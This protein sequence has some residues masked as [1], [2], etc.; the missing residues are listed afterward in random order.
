MQCLSLAPFVPCMSVLGCSVVSNS[1]WP[2]MDCS[3]PGFSVHGIFQARILERV[4]ISYS[5]GSS[6]PMDWTR[7]LGLLHWQV[8]SLPLH[9]LW[10]PLCLIYCHHKMVHIPWAPSCH[11]SV[12]KVETLRVLTIT[13]NPAVPSTWMNQQQVYNTYSLN[14]NGFQ[15]FV[16]G[17]VSFPRCLSHSGRPRMNHHFQVFD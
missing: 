10:S 8:D 7:F 1:W 5:R 12:L 11:D 17:K 6:W 2:Q 16:D 4:A 9:C 3:L 15:P 14:G 13:V